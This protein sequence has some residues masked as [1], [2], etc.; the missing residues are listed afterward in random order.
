M[1]ERDYKAMNEKLNNIEP[2]NN[3]AEILKIARIQI[4]ERF[5]TNY[6]SHYEIMSNKTTGCAMIGFL[7]CFE[8][9][10]EMKQKP[11]EKISHEINVEVIL[12]C[13]WAIKDKDQFYFNSYGKEMIEKCIEQK[14]K[15]EL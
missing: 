6:K 12:K 9:M 10:N 15:K 4:N 2:K 7:K 14:I 1:D 8:W 5:F 3:G 11:I 13:L